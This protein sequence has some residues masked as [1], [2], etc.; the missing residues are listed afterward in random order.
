M[1]ELSY[2]RNLSGAMKASFIAL[3]VVAESASRSWGRAPPTHM[4]PAIAIIIVLVC[5][6]LAALALRLRSRNRRDRQRHELMARLASRRPH[7]MVVELDD[8]GGDGTRL[9]LRIATD[10]PGLE[11]HG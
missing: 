11:H 9:R 2:S 6:E 3:K 1:N 8:P 4:N 7:D 10:Q 5:A